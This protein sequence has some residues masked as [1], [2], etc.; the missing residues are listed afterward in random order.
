ML[1]KGRNALYE[2]VQQARQGG[3]AIWKGVEQSL[4]RIS[5][6]EPS[7]RAWTHTA[8]LAQLRDQGEPDAAG[9]LAGLPFGVKDILNVAGMPTRCGSQAPTGHIEDF[10]ACCVAMLRHAGA[11]PVGK[12]VTTEYAFRR[13]GATCNPHHSDHTPGGSSSG[14]AAAVAAGVVPLALGTQTGG[15]MIRPAA[16]CGVVGFKP[17]FGGVFRDGLKL[18]C[19]SL[20]VIGWYTNTVAEAALVADVLLPYG[21]PV[22]AVDRAPRVALVADSPELSL[23]PEAAA[24]LQH[25]AEQLRAHGIVCE[26]PKAFS[27]AAQLADIHRVVMEYELA[28][29]LMSVARRHADK[30]SPGVLETVARGLS[31]PH[32]VYLAR[33]REQQHLRGQ[34]QDMM[35]DADLIVTPSAPGAAPKGLSDTGSSAFNRIWSALGWPCLHLPTQFSDAGLPL[36]VQLVGNFEADA[37]LL[38]W[39][40]RI[41]ELIRR[42]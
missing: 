41:H 16:F 19:E 30:L 8:T 10:D 42:N 23:E 14:S 34:W 11:V 3:D 33:R 29:S 24:A 17:S 15:S 26:T 38:A 28:H 35:G 40:A 31:I 5:E 13:P 6:R 39:G 18:T 9:S 20:D 21:G 7:L 22:Q 1:A 37:D 25:A 12:T 2:T 27:Q 32:D 4:Q 36:G